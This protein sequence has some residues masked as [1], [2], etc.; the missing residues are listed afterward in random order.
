MKT[1]VRML[2]VKV[3]SLAEEARIIRLEESRAGKDGF[4]RS[5]LH[6]HRVVD[7]CKE[8]RSSL[9][10]YGFLRGVEYAAIEAKTETPPDW[11][12][13]AKLVSK[14][15]VFVWESHSDA[16]SQAAAFEEWKAKASVTA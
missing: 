15:G 6:H 11:P 16:K 8:Q 9:L 5:E 1:R 12:R 14:F 2:K 4:L 10:A 3:K 13:V 7:V